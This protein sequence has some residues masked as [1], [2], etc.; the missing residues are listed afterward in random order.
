MRAIVEINGVLET[1][2]VSVYHETCWTQV[3]VTLRNDNINITLHDVATGGGDEY[4]YEYTA[5][6]LIDFLSSN[7]T[8]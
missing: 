8:V 6:N 3:D 2:S 7:I 5:D 1:V 4:G